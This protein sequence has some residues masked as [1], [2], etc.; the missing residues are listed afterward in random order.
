MATAFDHDENRHTLLDV[1]DI[2]VRR[3]IACFVEAFGAA[4]KIDHVNTRES[5]QYFL[6][7]LPVYAA[8]EP[9]VVRDKR[10]NA[11]AIFSLTLCA[12]RTN[13]M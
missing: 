11:F 12:I 8:I 10:D 3:S 6:T 4:M 5:A 13:L 7:H 2:P 9:A 1:K